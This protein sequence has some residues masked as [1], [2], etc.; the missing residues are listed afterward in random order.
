MDISAD[1]HA[2]E[3][4]ARRDALR[5]TVATTSALLEELRS[6]TQNMLERLRAANREKAVARQESS[7]LRDALFHLRKKRQEVEARLNFHGPKYDE[8]KSAYEVLAK[9]KESL[10][11]RIDELKTQIG[12]SEI[13][14][15]D[16]DREIQELLTFSD[17]LDEAI[18]SLNSTLSFHL[19]VIS[20]DKD[21]LL[22]EVH[23]LVQRSAELQKNLQEVEKSC[24]GY[25]SV[26]LLELKDE[27]SRLESELAKAET[28]KAL[29]VSISNAR[30]DS[31]QM[32]SESAV[33]G[34]LL[35]ERRA[36][37]TSRQERIERLRQE[38]LGSRAIA[39]GLK[40]E[41][42]DYMKAQDML[43]SAKNENEISLELIGH[44]WGNLY[45]AIADEVRLE[46]EVGVME[47][48]VKAVV[49]I[50]TVAPDSWSA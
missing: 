40:R 4:A 28:K 37:L 38:T 1:M 11:A 10:D 43:A 5:D 36:L 41:V 48:K 26:R 42:E 13:K 15:T 14:N 25:R 33:L 3:P 23:N 49:S 47:R 27:I 17:E 16:L 2:D 24:S 34:G 31:E 39:A 32:S 19:G 45:D 21:G 20:L 12:L 29:C 7:R 9:R 35:E 18:S 46:S 44:S 50:L 6:K 30:E 8:R 22:A